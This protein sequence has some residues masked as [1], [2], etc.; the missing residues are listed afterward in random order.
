MAMSRYEVF[1]VDLDPTLSSEIKKT[2]P[3]LV[4]S[5]DEM[6]H[7][8]RTVIVAPLPTQG[9][10]YPT[11]VHCRFAGTEGLVVLDP[12]RTAD[13]S[14]LAQRLGRIDHKTLAAVAGIL[15]EMFAPW[16]PAP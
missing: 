8:I 1:L 2:R 15:G 14:R 5:P 6:N 9:R 16:P 11:R 10:V 13:R 4:V 3:C 7:R 12:I